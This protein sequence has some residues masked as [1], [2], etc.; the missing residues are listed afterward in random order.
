MIRNK[1]KPENIEKIL[2]LSGI[3]QTGKAYASLKQYGLPT[4]KL[5]RWKYSD[6]NKALKTVGINHIADY[7]PLSNVDFVKAAELERTQA[8]NYDEM[9]QD[10]CS[11]S[12]GHKVTYIN[13]KNTTNTVSLKHITNETNALCVSVINLIIDENSSCTLIEDFQTDT[14]NWLNTVINI[15]LRSGAKLLHTRKISSSNSVITNHINVHQMKDSCYRSYTMARDVKFVRDEYDIKLLE[16][17]ANADIKAVS[18]LNNDAHA[19]N[20]IQ[21][22]HI[23]PNC[24]SKQFVR[25]VLDGKSR[26]VFQGK[27]HVYPNAQHTNGSQM[28]NTLLLAPTCEMNAK[29]ELEIYADDVVC[30]HGSTMGQMDEEALFYMSS[31]GIPPTEA[32]VLMIKA[33]I[34]EVFQD[35]PDSVSPLLRGTSDA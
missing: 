21:I 13:K 34:A 7:K 16:Q 9:L 29:P 4:K 6:L 14:E 27:T 17:G 26:G 5:E 30:S 11:V 8:D 20:T 15:E 24:T 33:F 35:C 10:L 1:Y 18:V 25:N 12:C 22:S 2:S 19:D 31:R 3:N 32:K 28:C 23:A